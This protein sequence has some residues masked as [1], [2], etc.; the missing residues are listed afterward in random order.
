MVV[1]VVLAKTAKDE[2]EE[3]AVLVL[4]RVGCP[5]D[6]LRKVLYGVALVQV[7]TE[8][9]QVVAVLQRDAKNETGT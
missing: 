4:V 1:V 7:V 3:G 8:I 2:E 9:V 6:A 5:R